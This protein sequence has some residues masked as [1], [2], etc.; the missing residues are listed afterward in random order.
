MKEEK[1]KTGKLFYGWILAVIFGAMF[2]MANGSLANTASVA[3]PLM[4]ADLEMSATQVSTGF[5]VL[6]LM[7]GFGAP[8][9]GWLVDRL[10]V[11]LTQIIGGILLMVCAASMIFLVREPILYTV[12]FAVFGVAALMVGQIAVQSAI[13]FW[14][15]KYRGMAMTIAMTIGGLGAFGAPLIANGLITS[16]GSWRSAWYFF[17]ITGALAI[18]LALVFVKNDPKDIGQLPDGGEVAQETPVE[19]KPSRVYKNLEEVTYAQTIKTPAY[20]LLIVTAAGAFFWYTLCTGLSIPH[21]MELGIDRLVAI[22]GLSSMGL[23][24]LIGKFVWGAI[25]DYVEPIRLLAVC[26]VLIFTG[27]VLAMFASNTFMVYAFYIL[28]GFAYGGIVPNLP[29]SIANYFGKT[30]FAKNLGTV[31]LIMGITS[32]ALPVV[33]GILFDLTHSYIPAFVITAAIVALSIICGFILRIPKAE[34][35]KRVPAEVTE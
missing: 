4:A 30:A 33:G 12:T 3:N 19:V 13:G 23:A 7:Y 31:M 20:W 25:S 8:I 32:S 17:L 28:S 16:G 22:G 29:T 2:F 18:I 11:R 6:I 34:L 1:M 15:V 27:I 14:F 10:G 26:E 35:A 9:A 24:M 5:T 21:F